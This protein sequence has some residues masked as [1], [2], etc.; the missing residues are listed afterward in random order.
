MYQVEI[1]YPD[2]SKAIYNSFTLDELLNRLDQG[3]IESFKI[4]RRQSRIAPNPFIKQP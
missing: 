1:E 4:S 3:E 2:G